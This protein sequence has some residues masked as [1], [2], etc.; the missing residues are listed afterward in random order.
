[1]LIIKIYNN[2]GQLV[3]ITILSIFKATVFAAEA[4]YFFHYENKADSFY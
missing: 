4:I 2:H 3:G 1:L